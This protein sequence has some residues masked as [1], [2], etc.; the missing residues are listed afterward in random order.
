MFVN[1]PLNRAFVRVGDVVL[2]VHQEVIPHLLG[3]IVLVGVPPLLLP[4]RGQ[5]ARLSRLC[6]DR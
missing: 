2:A 1:S 3:S 4:G 6:N 5:S